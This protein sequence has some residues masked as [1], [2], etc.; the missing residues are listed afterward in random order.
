[1]CSLVEGNLYSIFSDMALQRA[2]GI[3]PS[4]AKVENYMTIL[5]RQDQFA[6]L[7]K[8]LKLLIDN[9]KLTNVIPLK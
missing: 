2:Q 8:D 9:L 4:R 3:P 5:S 7:R 6:K 1:M